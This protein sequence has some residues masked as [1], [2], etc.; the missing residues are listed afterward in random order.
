MSGRNLRWWEDI[1]AVLIAY[2]LVWLIGLSVQDAGAA[3]I[4]AE[5]ER[6]R[7]YL[8]RE[9]RFV[10][11]MGA[12]VAT[13]GAQVHQESAWKPDARSRFAAG[14]AQFTPGT[15]DWIGGVYPDLAHRAPLDPR[16]ALRALVR[17]DRWL[18]D[19]LD[20][21]SAC[22]RMAFTLAGYNGGLGWIARE[23]RAAASVGADPDRWWAQVERHCLRAEWACRE[24]R[25]YPRKILLGWQPLYAA[26]GPGVA[27]DIR[28][29][30]GCRDK[31]K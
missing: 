9:A 7:G 23:K 13:F 15:A 3:Q 17:Y 26:W 11:G 14:L 16:W 20:A 2:V 5:A 25:D 10:W 31:P 19:R 6:H 18:W 28:E 8:T 29:R 4:P 12:P 21:A 24:N 30:L 22:D 1:D 27:C